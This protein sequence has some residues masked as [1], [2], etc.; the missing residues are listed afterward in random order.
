[1][2]AP[3]LAIIDGHY[4]AY[5]FFFGMPPLTG[6]GGRPTGVTYAYANLL[7]DLKNNPE[8]THWVAA[9]DTDRC[10]RNDLDP[11]YKAHRD[12][13]PE[14][15]TVQ[16][17]DVQR[18][19]AATGCPTLSCAGYE[20]DDV[21][22]TYAK[23]AAAAGFEV[24]L[25]TRDKDVDQVLSSQIRTWDPGKAILRGPAE[26]F[27][28]KGIRP[29][30]VVD[31]LSMIG[32]SADNITGI[33][34]VG[35]KTAAKLLGQ[36]D[37]L[38]AVFAN[39]DQLKGKT[40]ENVRNFMPVAEHTRRMITLVDVPGIPAIET[41]RIDR[42]A[43]IDA[44][45]YTGFG[46]SVAKFVKTTAAAGAKV[47]STAVSASATL[48][49]EERT[50]VETG[51]GTPPADEDYRLLTLADLPAYL[52]QLRAAGRFAIDTET[53]G[54][55][56]HTAELVGI[57]FA[58]GLPFPTS[59]AYLP[60]RAPDHACTPWA[61]LL[62]L[63]QPLL[64]DATVKKIGQNSKFDER[65]FLHHG[66]AIHGY[67]GDPMI[68]SWLL[69][70]SRESHG[71][72]FLSQS[73]LGVSK[74]PT[75]A[76]IDLKAGQTMDTVALATVQRYACEDAQCTWRLAV[77]LEAKLAD[78]HLLNVYR[79]QELPISRVLA[80]IEHRG[81]AVDRQVLGD[82]QTH[83]QQYLTQV[84]ADIRRH[85]GADF[86][87]ASPKQ[88]AQVLFERLKLPVISSTKSG[89]STDATV[90]EALRQ[91]HELP[92]LIL[93]WRSLSKLIG[94]Y[95][96]KLPEHINPQTRRIHTHFK[97][98]GTET[99]R[100][101]SDHPNLQN[102]PQKSDVGREIRAAFVAPPGRVLIAA[103]Y[104]QIE[105]RVLAHL[106]DDPTLIAAFMNHADIHRFVAAQVNHCDEAAVTP[107]QRNAA[108]AVNFGIIYGQTAFGLANQLGIPRDE[109]SRFI[110][111]YFARF[112]SVKAFINR[113][114]EEAAVRGYASTMAGRR[115][116]LPLLA[117]ANRNERMQ[118]ERF[119]LN[120]T[121]QGS[122]ADLIKVAMLRAQ[123]LLPPTAH[124]IL[125]IHDELLVEAD[126]A[127]A[128]VAAAALTDAMTGAWQLAVP[129]IADARIGRT[130]L[131]VS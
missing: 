23:Q 109:A 127:S 65:I 114:V 4:Y 47:T 54:L 35:P 15:L 125:Q 29:D 56:P 83:L 85:T 81:I 57:S 77:L 122:A 22:A 45:V 21:L 129:L 58:C 115:R 38:A 66:I 53:T 37:T 87:P 68:A 41:L 67:D 100:L 113:T 72:D 12:P 105:L 62:P 63:I 60:V 50:I 64:E 69:N 95:L 25:L 76:V 27:A 80:A 111:D 94:T 28:E 82:T 130:W 93:Q 98:T 59:A 61:E 97:Q 89:P 119:A 70:P 36:Y 34:G 55:D 33:P 10:F 74:I 31:Y 91:H 48:S 128:E 88:V 117:S 5:R 96:S 26:L 108:K 84:E 7:R 92:D 102:I 14:A 75:A 110:N 11:N 16:F 24:R 121:I 86:N 46:F 6:P 112:S 124:L 90:L 103:D 30:Q 3:I 126:E 42:A 20:A 71:L 107:A 43:A 18:L 49:V 2:S 51:P 39:I 79:E 17:P 106:S 13:T 104:S 123:R 118:G 19:L 101:S 120:S 8:I 73:F 44:A 99:G 78:D 52:A 9:F 116:H 40:Q 131:A 1:M 32:D